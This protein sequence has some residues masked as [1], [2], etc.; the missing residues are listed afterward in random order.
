MSNDNESV[1]AV[2]EASKID[3]ATVT[4]DMASTLMVAREW[5]RDNGWQNVRVDRWT[6]NSLLIELGYV[7]GEV[8]FRGWQAGSGDIKLAQ[9]TRRPGNL[10]PLWNLISEMEGWN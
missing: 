3:T 8:W 4:P 1:L 6:K 2:V 9:A 5:L 7:R 10:E